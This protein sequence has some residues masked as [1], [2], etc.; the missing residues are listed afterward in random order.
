MLEL[1][2]GQQSEKIIVTLT[3]LTTLEAPHYL[4]VFT[5][6]ATKQ[7]VAVVMG[8]DESPYPD[9][10]NQFDINTA[11]YFAGMPVGEWHY[12]AY[13]QDNPTNTNPA[14]TAGEVEFGKMR[15]SSETDFEFTQYHQPA[16]Y[17]AYNG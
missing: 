4:F 15:L 11:T 1:T 9:R 7:V 14:F 2:A 10:Y 3:E 13:Q 16:T 5:H 6:V 12:T 8:A 17:K